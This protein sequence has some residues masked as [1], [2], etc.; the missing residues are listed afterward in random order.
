MES[1]VKRI[2]SHLGNG[3]SL[4]FTLI[5]VLILFSNMVGRAKGNAVKPRWSFIKCQIDCMPMCMAIRNVKLNVCRIACRT[6]CQQLKGRGVVQANG[7][8]I[9]RFAPASVP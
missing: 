6:G 9:P 8:P 4:T 2:K 1:K 3:G 5:L 7:W